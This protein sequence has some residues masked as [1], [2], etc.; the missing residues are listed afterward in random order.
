MYNN[1]SNKGIRMEANKL[2]LIKA[3]SYSNL[4]AF[5]AKV[6]S[7]PAKKCGY[8]GEDLNQIEEVLVEDFKLD[9]IIIAV[10]GD[11]IVG[12]V[13]FDYEDEEAEVWGPVV[14]S[15][16]PNQTANKLWSHH[17]ITK[18]NWNLHFFYHVNNVEMRT[19]AENLNASILGYHTVLQC[20]QLGSTDKTNY[21][22]ID[23][24]NKKMI[25]SFKTLHDTLFPDTY[26]P[27]KTIL[28]RLTDEHRLLIRT[29]DV[30][31]VIG[32]AY[33]EGS[34][35]FKEGSVEFIGVDS[36]YRKQGVGK[37]LL[38]QSMT[39]LM[40]E[41]EIPSL[42]LTV[43]DENIGAIRLYESV[44]FRQVNNFVHYELD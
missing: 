21:E 36:D 41:M 43:N 2:E 5:L 26:Y 42:Y 18:Q 15:E 7:N 1:L 37:Q 13:A 12:M 28:E 23:L 22:E 24:N 6:N 10:E 19:F 17:P 44:G 40:Q 20:N 11:Q 35:Q 29:N 16:N 33:L 4:A 25:G 38:Q 8:I 3:T 9:E 32:Y 31:D 30:N 14:T 34:K 39:L 27:A